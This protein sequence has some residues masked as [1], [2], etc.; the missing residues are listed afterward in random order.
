MNSPNR[1]AL[2]VDDDD[3]VARIVSKLLSKRDLDVIV[4]QTGAEANEAFISNGGSLAIA[5]I[6]LVLPNGI[7]G[8]DII[9]FARKSPQ[10]SGIPIIILTGAEISQDEDDRLKQKVS[11]IVIKKDFDIDG[12]DRILDKLIR[13]KVQ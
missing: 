9:D 5:V 11:A 4:A 1:K 3:L 7:T 12:F 6:D 2:V 10:T 8:W 13:D